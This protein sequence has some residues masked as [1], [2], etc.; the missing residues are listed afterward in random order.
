MIR[1]ALLLSASLLALPLAARAQALAATT[2]APAA[3][4]Q[5][6]RVEG[7]LDEVLRRL[8]QTRSQSSGAVQ[9]TAAALGGSD[10]LSCP[11]HA[12]YAFSGGIQARCACHRPCR[13][14]ERERLARHPA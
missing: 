5:L 13:A 2:P 14:T 7:K 9:G 11:E 1:P 10:P 3:P 6:D 12:S 8:D 4:S